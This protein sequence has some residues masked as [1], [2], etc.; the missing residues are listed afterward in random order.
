MDTP[1]DRQF[2]YESYHFTTN[3]VIKSVSVVENVITEVFSCRKPY[4]EKSWTDPLR[5]CTQ[6]RKFDIDVDFDESAP[7]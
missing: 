7:V 1:L 2:P 3:F 6:F 4:V 5:I